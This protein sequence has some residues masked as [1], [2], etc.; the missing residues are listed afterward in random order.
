MPITI[1]HRKDGTI[2]GMSAAPAE[3]APLV[4]TSS[5]EDHGRV[6]L[7]GIRATALEKPG[8]GGDFPREAA[9]QLGSRFEDVVEHYR[10][11]N[12]TLAKRGSA[13]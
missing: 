9:E 8:G 10:I 3:A 13:R 5:E 7:R 6:G 11:E 2:V 12:G 1:F 4:V